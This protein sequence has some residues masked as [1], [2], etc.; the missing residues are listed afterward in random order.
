MRNVIVVFALVLMNNVIADE[1]IDN[2]VELGIITNNEAEL[3][4]NGIENGSMDVVDVDA[5]EGIM[6]FAVIYYDDEEP[7]ETINV[8]CIKNK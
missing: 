7:E 6:T 1:R 5:D 8:P 2:A 3:I 4:E